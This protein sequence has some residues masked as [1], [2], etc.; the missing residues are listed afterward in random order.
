MG[1]KDVAERFYEKV[2]KSGD[3]WLWRASKDKHGYGR[4]MFPGNRPLKA[5]RVSFE[6]QNGPIPA[7]MCVCHRCDNP[8]CVRPDHLFLGSKAENSADMVQKQRQT[9]KLDVDQ[10]REIRATYARGN[11]NQYLLAEQF[12][13]SQRQ[14]GRIVNRRNWVHT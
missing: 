12:N 7:G 2:D 14:I 8:S 10:V 13:V 6:L 11:T 5:H 9:R 1:M 4:I 3:C